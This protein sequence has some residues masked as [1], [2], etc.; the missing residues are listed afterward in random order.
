M[1]KKRTVHLHTRR[2]REREERKKEHFFLSSFCSVS[3][4][5]ILGTFSVSV[6]STFDCFTMVARRQRC[7]VVS[8]CRT[9]ELISVEVE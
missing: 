6:V 8:E 9:D 1:M 2:Q 4:S 5:R 7:V 3:H